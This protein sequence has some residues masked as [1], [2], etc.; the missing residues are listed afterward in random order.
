MESPDAKEGVKAG[1]ANDGSESD[2][3]DQ[4][5]AIDALFSS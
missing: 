3:V 2:V 1:T 4:A 5:E